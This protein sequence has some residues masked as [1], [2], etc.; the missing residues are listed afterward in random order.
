[1][2]DQQELVDHLVVAAGVGGA[3]AEIRLAT[4]NHPP[5]GPEG[6]V[7]HFILDQ[8]ESLTHDTHIVTDRA[9]KASTIA[10]TF[11]SKRFRVV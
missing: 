7:P 1:M 3:C 11:R 9:Q 6:G 10:L 5:G 4:R 2:E 8:E